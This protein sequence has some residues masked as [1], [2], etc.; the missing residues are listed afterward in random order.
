MIYLFHNV[1]IENST[2][3]LTFIYIY[4]VQHISIQ[5]FVSKEAPRMVPDQVLL[6]NYIEGHRN[7]MCW[8]WYLFTAFFASL[9]ITLVKINHAWLID[10]IKKCYLLWEN[11]T[12][13][14]EQV[15]KYM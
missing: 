1:N 9:A 6:Y 7:I 4:D 8:Y 11:Y 12:H 10:L 14:D 15:M 3:K 5:P 13:T 2:T